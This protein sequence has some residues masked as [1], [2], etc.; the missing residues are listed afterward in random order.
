MLTNPIKCNM[1]TYLHELCKSNLNSLEFKSLKHFFDNIANSAIDQGISDL[2]AYSQRDPASVNKHDIIFESY[3]S[4]KAVLGY[5]LAHNI[6][7]FSHEHNNKKEVIAFKISNVVKTLSGVD[8][9]PRAQIGKNFVIDHGYGTVIGETSEIGNDCYFL[10]GVILGARG[11]AD[12][13]SGKRH[14][15]IGNNVE[16]GSWVRILGP[17][18]IGNNVFISPNCIIT[19]S[20]PSDARVLSFNQ[21][22]VNRINH[23]SLSLVYFSGIIDEKLILISEE[24]D[25]FKIVFLDKNFLPT[26]KINA[27]FIRRKDIQFEYKLTLVGDDNYNFEYP[28][29]IEITN[30]RNSFILINPPGL[31]DFIKNHVSKKSNTLFESSSAE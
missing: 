17:I 29:N 13:P 15:K 2:N 28:L 12:N 26:N 14:P 6:L 30:S 9:H 16:I 19:H 21:L 27:V 24:K 18:E 7:C 22:Q 25:I 10:N 8:I 31:S 4:F 11:I 20:L 5:R 3:S 1:Y 23:S